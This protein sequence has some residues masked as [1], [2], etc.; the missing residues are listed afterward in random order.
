MIFDIEATSLHGTKSYPI[1][2]AWQS[3]EGDLKSF[4]INLSSVADVLDWSEDSENIHGIS[5]DQSINEGFDPHDVVRAFMDDYDGSPPYS[6]GPEYDFYWI[7]QLFKM[8]GTKVP[9][10]QVI[11]VTDL[12]IREL[13]KNGFSPKDSFELANQIIEN[14]VDS[15]RTHRAAGDVEAV[16]HG[17]NIAKSMMPEV[18]LRRDSS[19]EFG[20]Y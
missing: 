2:I 15:M 13:K 10:N 6:D 4:L 7:T 3:S 1:E 5:L 19:Y 18:K 16:V 11:P 17:L 9:F 14:D 8:A 20:N 12:Y